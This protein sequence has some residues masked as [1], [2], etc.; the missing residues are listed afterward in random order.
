MPFIVFEGLDGSGK[1]TLMGELD[2]ILKSQKK[3][4]VLTREP[5][6]TPFCDEIRNLILR[7]GNE[8]P[9]PRA[10]LLLYEASRAQ[11][12]DMLITPALKRGDW[13]LCDRFSASSTAFQG[14]GRQISVSQVEWLNS[15]ATHGLIPDVT[16]LLDIPFDE[17]LKRRQ[18]RE[19]STGVESDRIESEARDFHERV[20]ESFLAQSKSQ[21]NWLVLDARK[22]APELVKDLLN[23]LEEKKW[24]AS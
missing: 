8:V 3:T 24:L 20:R 9:T 2:K 22:T 10:E 23:Y 19:K 1:S 13:V 7:K 11:H 17:S 5:G 14:G 15:F 21:S 18:G 6:G 12:V 16:I 4:T